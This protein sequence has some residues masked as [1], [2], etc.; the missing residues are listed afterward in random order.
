MDYIYETMSRAKEAIA[1]SFS[2]K[3]KNYEEAI[4][5]IDKRWEC[6]LHQPLHTA[7][8][9][10]NP[11]IYYSNPSIEDCSAVMKGLFD[12]IARMTPNLETQ[13]NILAE[14]NSYKT[15]QGL[16]GMPM[17]ISQRKS[18]AFGKNINFTLIRFI[19]SVF[20]IVVKCLFYTF[21]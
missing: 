13:A 12:Y 18:L 4:K 6:Q 16:F 10:L 2:N 9:Y 14:L 15:S 19:I 17:A 1:K 20:F 3:E 21:L 5:Y 7:G 8:H 11:K